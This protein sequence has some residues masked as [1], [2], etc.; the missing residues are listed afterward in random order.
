MEAAGFAYDSTG[1]Y[2][3]EARIVEGGKADDQ[4]AVWFDELGFDYGFIDEAHGLKNL[5]RMSK[6]PRIAGLPFLVCGG[7]KSAYD[8]ALWAL[9]W[10][11]FAGEEGQVFDGGPPLDAVTVR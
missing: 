7:L 9:D 8:L 1:A 11:A 10:P 5:G 6:M 3:T 2:L 4:S